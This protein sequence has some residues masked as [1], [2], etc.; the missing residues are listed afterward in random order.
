MC[1]GERDCSDGSDENVDRCVHTTCSSSQFT[2]ARSR[3]CIPMT[4]VCDLDHDCG[5]GDTSDEANNCSKFL[6]QSIIRP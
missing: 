1:D 3:R 4:W 6:L 2:C 5:E